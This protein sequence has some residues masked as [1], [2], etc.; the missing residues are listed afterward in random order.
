MKNN[1]FLAM[2]LLFTA[3]S[4]LS[5]GGRK[6]NTTVE[7]TGNEF[8]TTQKVQQGTQEPGNITEEQEKLYNLGFQVPQQSL[9]APDFTLQNLSGKEVSLSDFHG[10]IVFLNF[11]ATWCP[12]C[13]QEMPSM[14]RLHETFKDNDFVM[15]AVNL[16]ESEAT[17]KDFLKNNPYTFPVLL[18]SE[19]AIGGGMF[20]VSSI[21][22]TYLIDKEGAILA[23]LIGTREWDTEEIISLFNSLL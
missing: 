13:R 1:I 2:I 11:W 10:N 15:L 4:F 12:P 19:G 20:G 3:V 18:D 16:Q 9:D 14:Q 17:V 8:G 5:A 6:E 23:R 22:T 7:E 21:P